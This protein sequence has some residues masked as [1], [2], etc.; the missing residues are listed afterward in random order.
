M[1]E[2]SEQSPRSP[3][4]NLKV[5]AGCQK[6]ETSEAKW[7]VRARRDAVPLTNGVDP[8]WMRASLWGTGML[9]IGF[10]E[11]ESSQRFHQHTKAGIVPEL[12]EGTL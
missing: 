4:R 9:S 7:T 12:F 10:S 8:E 6:T 1:V 2:G 5:I 3:G 11:A